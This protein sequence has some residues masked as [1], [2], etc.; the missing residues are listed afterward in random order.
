MRYYVSFYRNNIRVL[1]Y[2]HG[3]AHVGKFW[4]TDI[5]SKINIFLKIY[6]LSIHMYI[7]ERIK[8]KHAHKKIQLLDVGLHVRY[9][10]V[11]CEGG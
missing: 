3:N 5:G 1:I 11:N 9:V 4:E 7:N 6:L 10:R 8:A 2:V